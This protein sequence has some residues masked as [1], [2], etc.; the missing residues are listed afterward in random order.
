MRVLVRRQ[1]PALPAGAATLPAGGVRKRRAAASEPEKAGAG[2]PSGPRNQVA[3]SYAHAPRVV[4]RV[5]C[6]KRQRTDQAAH[7]DTPQPGGRAGSVLLPPQVCLAQGRRA[8][9]AAA[10]CPVVSAAKGMEPD[11][12]VLGPGTPAVREPAA[13]VGGSEPVRSRPDPTWRG[14]AT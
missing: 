7:P 1:A 3:G 14:A 5:R 9:D 6:S 8:S 4:L 13:A 10:D 12:A 2:A 11:A